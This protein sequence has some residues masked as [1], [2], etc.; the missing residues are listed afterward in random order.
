MTA[1]ELNGLPPAPAAEPETPEVP[2]APDTPAIGPRC[3]KRLGPGGKTA[4]SRLDFVRDSGKRLPK[5]RAGTVRKA[6]GKQAE[7][8]EVRRGFVRNLEKDFRENR[9]EFVRKAKGKKASAPPPKDEKRRTA[10]GADKPH[11]SFWRAGRTPGK[12]RLRLPGHKICGRWTKTG[13]KM[14]RFVP[15]KVMNRSRRSQRPKA[16]QRAARTK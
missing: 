11:M 10:K 2:E 9:L 12:C 15:P 1:L 8:A 13:Y 3:R 16:P 4:E 5:V 6:D 14:L 7:T